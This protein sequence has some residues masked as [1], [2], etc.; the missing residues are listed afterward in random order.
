V[1]TVDVYIHRAGTAPHGPD[2]LSLHNGLFGPATTALHG[3]IDAF[4]DG[5]L[6][7]PWHSSHIKATVPG[8]V[9]CSV[10]GRIDE[11]DRDYDG[12][13]RE[14]LATF[15]EALDDSAEYAVE[16]IEV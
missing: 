10:L 4:R 13:V 5:T 12:A 15:R 16:A 14:R 11:N 1:T 2:S 9:V 3:L 8:S 7:G 6:T